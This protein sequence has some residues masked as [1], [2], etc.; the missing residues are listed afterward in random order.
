MSNIGGMP[1]FAGFVSSSR[2]FK[3]SAF[4]HSAISPR[5]KTSESYYIR[6]SGQ[7]QRPKWEFG[8]LDGMFSEDFGG[9]ERFSGVNGRRASLVLD[10]MHGEIRAEK[11]VMLCMSA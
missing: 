3:T 4:N 9:L 11:A 1:V 7:S 2:T 10:Q 5:D 6:I 8:G